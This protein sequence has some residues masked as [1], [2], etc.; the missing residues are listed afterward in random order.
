MCSR[1][2]SGP[3]PEIAFVVNQPPKPGMPVRRI[4]VA[5]AEFTVPIRPIRIC[6]LTNCE[7]SRARLFRLN[8][9][10]SFFSFALSAI[11]FVSAAFSAGGFSQKT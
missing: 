2:I 3:P 4:Q 8:M 6:R 1:S 11:S 5:C 10:L 7:S 9:S